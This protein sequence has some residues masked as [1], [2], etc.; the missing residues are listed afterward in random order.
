MVTGYA[1]KNIQHPLN[2]CMIRMDPDRRTLLL[3]NKVVI[4]TAV[5]RM[6][7]VTRLLVRPCVCSSGAAL[8]SVRMVHGPFRSALNRDLVRVSLLLLPVFF[9]FR[10]YLRLRASMFRTAPISQNQLP[11]QNSTATTKTC[12]RPASNPV[13]NCSVFVVLQQ[14]QQKGRYVH[15]NYHLE[16]ARAG[17]NVKVRC[18]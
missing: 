2:S 7:R 14:R 6:F 15:V 9:T 1:Q 4:N 11:T 18:P 16:R 3:M 5:P 10:P 8:P 13:D 12:G 17:N